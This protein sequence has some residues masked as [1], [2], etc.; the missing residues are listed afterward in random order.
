MGGIWHNFFAPKTASDTYD[1]FASFKTAVTR[2]LLYRVS[3]SYDESGGESGK[4]VCVVEPGGTKLKILGFQSF[5]QDAMAGCIQHFSEDGHM[6]LDSI[7]E[8][9]VAFYGAFPVPDEMINEHEI[10]T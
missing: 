3:P 4:A 9:R 5:A 2:S 8:G 10:C 1:K 6:L 7:K